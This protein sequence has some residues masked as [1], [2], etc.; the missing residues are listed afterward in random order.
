MHAC[1]ATQS[2]AAAPPWLIEA[3]RV[4]LAWRK[5]AELA[6]DEEHGKREAKPGISRAAGALRQ[7]AAEHDDQCLDR[8]VIPDF[9]DQKA[10]TQAQNHSKIA[11]ELRCGR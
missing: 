7:K 9:F 11:R 2:T 1:H 8:R 4:C 5:T 6:P 3:G 10:N